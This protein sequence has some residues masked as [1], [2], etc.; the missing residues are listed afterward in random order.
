MVTTLFINFSD[1]QGELTP[2][3]VM[4]SCRNSN[5]F[6]PLWLVLLSAK[7]KKIHLKMKVLKWSQHFSHYKSMG[8]FPD[9]QGQL[10]HKF[11][12]QPCRISN[13]I[14]ILWLSLLPARMRKYQSK[15]KELE[16]SQDF[17][18]YTL[19]EISVAMGT[20]ILIRSSPKPNTVNHLLKWCSW[21]NLIMIGRLVSEILMFESVDGRTHERTH[22]RTDGQTPGRVPYYKLTLSLRLWWAKNEGARVVTTLFINFS[23]S[24]G[25]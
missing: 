5:S 8:I 25:S 10:T 16:W 23:D 13:P 2:K 14:E 6:E 19:W 22:G 7:M 15:M 1:A 12:V 21:W 9:A 11:L 24:K 20:R 3:S 18:H 4:E 17:P